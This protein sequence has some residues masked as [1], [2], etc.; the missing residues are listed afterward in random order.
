MTC[1]I[2]GWFQLA[3]PR[4]FTDNPPEATITSPRKPKQYLTIYDSCAALGSL[5]S[6]AFINTEVRLYNA[7]QDINDKVIHLW[8]KFSVVSVDNEKGP[9]LQVDA[10]HFVVNTLD[11]RGDF[12]PE[13]LRISVIVFGRVASVAEVAGN[14]D[15]FLMLEASDWVRDHNQTFNIRLVI[16][17]FTP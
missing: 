8:G 11:P 13:A 2:E 12:L 10:H 7:N 3:N 14:P 9:H 17:S 4:Q 1:L 6:K 15:K 5:A 16:R